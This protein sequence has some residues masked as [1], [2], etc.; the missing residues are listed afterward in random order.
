[1]GILRGATLSY[2]QNEND[3]VDYAVLLLLTT[4]DRTMTTAGIRED[5]G[6]VRTWE[7]LWN[8]IDAI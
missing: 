2:F 8:D 3:E 6:C 4:G 5:K 7:I 1:M